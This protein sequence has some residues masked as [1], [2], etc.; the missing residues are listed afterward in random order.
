[1]FFYGR[2]YWLATMSGGYFVAAPL[3]CGWVFP[4]FPYNLE[5]GQTP[6]FPVEKPVFTS[7][8]TSWE[9]LTV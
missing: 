5:T 3:T 9:C 7:P 1:M 4:V 2:H 8:T 6:R